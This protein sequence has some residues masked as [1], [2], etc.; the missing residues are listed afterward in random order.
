L[1]ICSVCRILLPSLTPCNTSSFL[2]RSVQMI[3]SI[4]LMQQFQNFPGISDLRSEVSTFQHHTKLCSKCSTILISSLNL[5][6]ICYWKESSS[7]WMLL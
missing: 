7:C 6:P 1:L 3:F 5:S 4:L 2:T